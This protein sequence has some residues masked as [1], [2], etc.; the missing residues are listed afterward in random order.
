MIY[1]A[2]KK[3]FKR[4]LFV[5]F[6][7]VALIPV[8]VSSLFLVQLLMSKVTREY[9]K[10]AMHQMDQVE[11][12]LLAFFDSI[13]DIQQ[14]MVQEEII[15][16]G[17]SEKDSWIRN[18][19]YKELYAATQDY[20]EYAQFDIYSTE[21]ECLFSTTS[22]D[23][24]EVLPD[25]WGILKVAKTH[26]DEMI[27]RKSFQRWNTQEPSLQLAR[28]IWAQEE[29]KGYLVTV[30][31]EECFEKIL[32][33]T[34]DM[35]NGI[36]ILDSFWEEVYSTKTAKE[37]SLAQT[38][39]TRRMG[40]EGLRQTTDG[41]NFFIRNIGESGLYLV[42]GK[43]VVFT[44][45]IV[46]T[47][48]GT[49]LTIALLCAV[50]C[51]IMASVMS[52][53]LT[54]PIERLT[55][56]MHRVENGD[57]DARVNTYRKD[58]LGQLSRTFDRMTEVLKK[59]MELQV[60]QQ[61]ELNDSNIAMMQAQLNPHFL[62]NTL[63]TMKWV[64]KANH[65]PELALLSSSLAKILRMSISET[66]FVTLA[67][68]IRFVSYYTDIQK[69]RFNGSF[70][71]DIELPMELEDCMVPKLII[72]PIVENAI[73][74]GF[75]EQGRGHI[76]VNVYAREEKL[77]IEV[78]DDGCGMDEEMIQ[79]LNSRNREKLRGHIGFYNVDTIIR[80]YYG[81]AYGMQAETMKEG[82]TRVTLTLP[83]VKEEIDAESISG[84]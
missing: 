65:V 79:L 68:E 35:Q 15:I 54:S 49:I 45:G 21:G 23:N 78:T 56:A 19:A 48:F 24:P 12:K 81:E 46:R 80:L 60:R 8:V 3:S 26:P 2:I 42:M 75:K 70:S 11:S 44:D 59:Y 84:R 20:R 66:K 4:E 36:A 76:F 25:Y 10:D 50:L 17:M 7:V 52:G 29:C 61:Q 37:E 58:E 40:S 83:V 28:A 1:A 14:E 77:Y 57:L 67:E 34:Y 73:I 9:E 39:R 16:R 82:G 27:I 33:N 47:M 38:L 53:Y 32:S 62:Y 13:D 30:I 69:I 72:Q 31:T 41:I 63:D 22:N 74:H 43:E 18:R 5:C 6:V 64:A 51:L 55:N 71:I